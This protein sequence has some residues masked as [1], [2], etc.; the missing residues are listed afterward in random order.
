MR[1]IAMAIGQTT[2]LLGRKAKR[3]RFRRR[4]FKDTD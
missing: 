3:R 1:H 2:Y 4:W